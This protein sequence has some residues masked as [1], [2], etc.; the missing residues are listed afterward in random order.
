M[1][2][3]RTPEQ[4]RAELDTEREELAGAVEYLREELGEATDIGGKLKS[5][6]PAVAAGAASVGFVLGGGVGATL[7]Y[8]ARRGRESD[9]KLRVGRWS[10]FDRD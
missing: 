4:I 5:K 2:A 6:L 9:E 10:I 8:L 3:V 1:A 7:R